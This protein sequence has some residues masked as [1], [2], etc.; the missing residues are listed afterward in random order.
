LRISD[1]INIDKSALSGLPD[2]LSRLNIGDVVRAKVLEISSDEI[3]LK[4][5]DGTIFKAAT[6]TRIDVERGDTV[7]F[8]VKGNVDSKI[9]METLKVGEKKE[10]EL[11]AEIKKELTES[12]IKPGS[13]NLEIAGELKERGLPISK[14]YISQVMDSLAKFKNLTIEKAA[15]LISKNIIPEEKSISSLNQIVD[16][17]LK[18]GTGLEDVFKDVMEINDEGFKSL[19]GEKLERFVSGG[20]DKEELLT[21]TTSKNHY[22]EIKNEIKK[23]IQI[24][25][26][27]EFVKLDPDSKI[28]EFKDRII[29][30]I[31]SEEECIKNPEK[32]MEHVKTDLKNADA[33]I[34]DGK[35]N[36][37]DA[38][39][40]IID[41]LKDMGKHSADMKN[42]VYKSKHESVLRKSLEA[43]FIKIDRDFSKEGIDMKKT[44]RDMF[45]KLDIIKGTLEQSDIPNKSELTNK[46]ESLQ[47]NIKFLNEINNHTSYV[48]M[49]L[50]IMDRSTTGELYVLKRESG[51]K[52]IDPQNTSV[53][54]SLNTQNLGQIDSLIKVERKNISINMRLEKEKIIDILKGKY[55]ELYNQLLEKGYKLVDIKYRLSGDEIN[56]LNINEVADKDFKMKRQN[57]DYKV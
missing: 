50:N 24:L 38:V 55:R 30:H 16:E 21:Q 28:Q 22:S 39:K 36:V 41:K 52:R 4:L 3:L 44:Y 1:F 5:F 19:L 11:Q 18:V 17:K 35:K 15:F 49:P 25:V 33:I 31:T 6:M 29:Q 47:N 9:F 45:E 27:S 48:Q 7:D 8:V 13:M 20:L 37:E 23:E 54:L 51:K 26:E 57:I 40:N 34:R 12:G 53:F 56:V 42:G 43:S 46:I 2:I 14:E 10:S 32:L